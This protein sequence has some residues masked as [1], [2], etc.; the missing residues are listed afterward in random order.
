[1]AIETLACGL[2]HTQRL[3]SIEL[4]AV[5]IQ[6]P[7]TTLTPEV[8]W[9]NWYPVWMRASLTYC[10]AME[11]IVISGVELKTLIVYQQTPRCSVPLYD[12]ATNIEMLDSDDVKNAGKHIEQ[13]SLSI[14]NK[15]TTGATERPPRVPMACHE[16]AW[17]RKR[18]PVITYITSL[19]EKHS[20]EDEKF[21]G[22]ARFLKLTPNLKSLEMHFYNTASG[23]FIGSQSIFEALKN[24]VI[25]PSLR[26][27]SVGG[28][29][30]SENSLIQFVSNRPQITDLTLSNITILSGGSRDPIFG[31][32][33]QR[34]PGLE[35]LYLSHL[36]SSGQR[37]I[38]LHP[39][40]DDRSR[41][42]G[43]NQRLGIHFVHSKVFDSNDIMK[44]L[45]FR[46][47]PTRPFQAFYSAYR[48]FRSVR[49]RCRSPWESNDVPQ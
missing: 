44:G 23:Q 11:A 2:K 46:P 43:E 34:R 8:G 42:L 37:T 30:T 25:L 45:E 20:S 26:K 29:F 38:N 48:Y 33:G 18:R 19:G 28:I 1:M 16:V 15:V 9:T 14:S 27:C 4:D 5:L 35:R 10:I 41:E 7:N 22:L 47:M 36:R 13:L 49:M 40:W 3:N 12:I 6:G 24:E 17:Y 21:D 32:L 39:V 31:H